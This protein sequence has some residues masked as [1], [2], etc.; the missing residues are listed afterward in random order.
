MKYI[1]ENFYDVYHYKQLFKFKDKFGPNWENRYII[2][3]NSRDL[4]NII[5]AFVNAYIPKL[6]L[7]DI[8]KIVT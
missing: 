8:L 3:P 1:Y 5:I 4:P 7:K 2:I 6:K